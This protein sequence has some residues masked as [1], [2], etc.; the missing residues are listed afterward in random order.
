LQNTKIKG[1][2]ILVKGGGI[3]GNHPHIY[4]MEPPFA[5]VANELPAMWLVAM[6]KCFT[7]D[8]TAL[9]NVNFN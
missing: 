4:P 7:S 8:R 2:D 6:A 9:R 3:I 1:T 5:L